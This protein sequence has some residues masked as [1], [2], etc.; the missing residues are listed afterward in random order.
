MFVQYWDV[1]QTA[2]GTG[3][4]LT[5]AIP[6]GYGE[7]LGLV[8]E[9]TAG[10][11]AATIQP[12]VYEASGG[13]PSALLYQPAAASAAAGGLNVRDLRRIG[14]TAGALYVRPNA[15]AAGDTWRVRAFWRVTS[16]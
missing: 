9:R 4:E 15:S 13:A 12:A 3:A 7:L 5:L 2:T 11:A 10:A 16:G 1:S 8:V 6:A 14:Q